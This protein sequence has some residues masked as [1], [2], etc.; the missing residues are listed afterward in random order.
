[1]FVR[2]KD[3]IH[4]VQLTRG[5]LLD[6]TAQLPYILFTANEKSSIRGAIF[7]LDFTFGTIC[8]ILRKELRQ[9][10]YRP[11]RVNRLTDKNKE[12]R[13]TFSHRLFARGHPIALT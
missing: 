11:T 3:C 12:D 8:Q 4:A 6:M 9:K 13:V 5:I 1:M 7:E 10:A 2:D